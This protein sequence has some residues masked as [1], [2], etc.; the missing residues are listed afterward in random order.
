MHEDA[1]WAVGE[2]ASLG[3]QQVAESG[4]TSILTDPVTGQL[5]GPNYLTA[6]A[7]GPSFAADEFKMELEIDA[8]EMHNHLGLIAMIAPS[9]DW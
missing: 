2:K 8:N 1:F 9:P 3:V 4:G 7:A 6:M 5:S